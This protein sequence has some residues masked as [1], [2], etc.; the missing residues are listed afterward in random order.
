MK[1]VLIVSLVF[2]FFIFT[3]LASLHPQEM[4]NAFRGRMQNSE[5]QQTSQQGSSEGGVRTRRLFTQKVGRSGLTQLSDNLTGSTVNQLSNIQAPNTHK[6]EIPKAMVPRSQATNGNL[7]APSSN[8]AGPQI[9][10][11]NFSRPEKIQIQKPSGLLGSI[12]NSLK[13]M[14]RNSF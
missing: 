4:Q 1:R 12:G 9:Q 14:M 2:L 8:I 10:K 13:G 6:V 3:S 11:P 5:M 7:I